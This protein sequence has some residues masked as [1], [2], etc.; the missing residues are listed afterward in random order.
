MEY[1]YVKV[2]KV[3]ERKEHYPE[4]SNWSTQV[5]VYECLCGAGTIEYY[6]VPGFD[7]D[8]FEFH[9][10]ACQAKYRSFIDWCGNE[11]KVYPLAEKEG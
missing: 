1:E 3:I 10:P 5:V 4:G 2:P 9:C 6:R 7:D 11:W 8:W